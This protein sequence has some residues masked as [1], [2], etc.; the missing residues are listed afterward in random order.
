MKKVS[1]ILLLLTICSTT[2]SQTWQFD[3]QSTNSQTNEVTMH[4]VGDDFIFYA[5]HD[6]FRLS[7]YGDVIQTFP[8]VFINSSN[9]N[10]NTSHYASKI[11]PVDN[12]YMMAGTPFRLTKVYPNGQVDW[13]QFFNAGLV[14]NHYNFR[15]MPAMIQDG[16][17][18]VIANGNKIFKVGA[19][20]NIISEETL[21]NFYA[22]PS[23]AKKENGYIFIGQE[24]SLKSFL[25]T[26]DENGQSESPL[27]YNALDFIIYNNYIYVV[28]TKDGQ[29]LIEKL[30][31]DGNMIWRKFYGSGV[32][33]DLIED[34]DD[35]VIVA[36]NDKTAILSKIDADGEV[37]WEETYDNATQSNL[38]I[39][40]I[41]TANG[42]L[43]ASPKTIVHTDKNGQVDTDRESLYPSTE[44]G[45]EINN[46]KT[47]V[48]PRVNLFPKYQPSFET[49]LENSASTIKGSNL[50]ITGYTN[51]QKTTGPDDF[52]GFPYAFQSGFIGS[53]PTHMEK[54]WKIRKKDLE[55]LKTDFEDNNQIDESIPSDILTYPAF[56]NTNARGKDNY[57]LN[58]T[59]DY[60][61][62]EDKN[63]DGVYNV[64]DGDLPI[65]KG[66]M[67]LVWFRNDNV[68][69]RN[70]QLKVDVVSYVYG[71]QCGDDLVENTL[72][73][74]FDIY[75]R[76]PM[77]LTD[78]HAGIWT[79]FALGCSQDDYIGSLTEQN[80][81][82]VYN[83]T[84]NDGE[85][86]H[87]LESS[88][89]AEIPIQS[90]T[91]LGRNMDYSGAYGRFNYITSHNPHNPNPN[92]VGPFSRPRTALEKHYFMTGRDILGRPMF[93]SN[94]HI[95]DGNPYDNNSWTMIRDNMLPDDFHV[96]A[97]SSYP[98]LATNDK[99]TLKAAFITH[100]G[101][102]YPKPD[103]ESV[104]NRIDLL[105]DF[106]AT[107][108]LNWDLTTVQ[109]PNST[110]NSIAIT[111]TILDG[112][113]N[114]SYT[115][116]WSNGEQ[117]KN[118][119]VTQSG[120]YSLEATNVATGCKET[121]EVTVDIE[122]Q[123]LT[124][125][126]EPTTFSATIY[127]NPTVDVFNINI[128][129]VERISMIVIIDAFG[130]RVKQIVYNGSETQEINVSDLNTGIYTIGFQKSS[131]EIIEM[132]KIVITK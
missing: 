36:G 114:G 113:P 47:S 3:L 42:Y 39:Q 14:G 103:I 121:V 27:N 43:F 66:D 132:K 111:A 16:D 61:E 40:L 74:E 29:I 22:I 68:P 119:N 41:N 122:P 53:N 69:N 44:K 8:S 32:A 15:K 65:I 11:I 6:F 2:F 70:D 98:N 56:G 26:I 62:F 49:N 91:L 128:Q 110:N 97:S 12:G 106:V 52:T 123:E 19:T 24:R 84:E 5:N 126:D 30:D 58:I 20:G 107:N 130:Q 101:I 45:I 57:P 112:N 64:F 71:Y 99:M 23:I 96:I 7:K 34:N 87:C 93:P 95:F 17:D 79:D 60:L 38:R 4:S 9:H 116:E 80:S 18:F 73:A 63:Q 131:G 109:T 77:T 13:N 37:I 94:N 127:P 46:I 85:G 117:G 21:N 48:K 89:T 115:F 118:I 102:Q 92:S 120:V 35:L 54:V 78:V 59:V 104:A 28:G 100:H 10:I 51:T 88:F 31:T 125:P 1:F 105:E 25:L 108:A 76:N 129:T 82:Y 72:F 50:W 124:A 83:S 75:S 55:R 90:V 86:L 67:M 81:V 33:F